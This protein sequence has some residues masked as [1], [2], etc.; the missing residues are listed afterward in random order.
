[1]SA[2]SKLFEELLAKDNPTAGDVHVASTGKDN[3]STKAQRKAKL[4]SVVNGGSRPV[5]KDWA[6]FDADRMAAGGKGG[7]GAAQH[8]QRLKDKYAAVGRE[9]GWDS[10]EAKAAEKE[11]LM[12]QRRY[13]VVKTD[14][15]RT[16][17][18]AKIDEDQRLVF[19]WAS[20]IEVNGEPVV[21]QQG[22]IIMAPEMEKSFYGFVTDSRMAGEM[23]DRMDAGHLVECIVFTKEK[24]EALGIEFTDRRVGTW[25]G[26]R[27]D[28]DAFAKVKS[29]DYRAFSI[30][31]R[32][33]RAAA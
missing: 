28:V 30:G 22:D 16:I 2:V 17:P 6:Q 33:V 26:F 11:M 23:H 21:D 32:G 7:R 20:V 29:G 15:S 14:W 19:G 1:M 5:A 8:L 12:A 13:G 3:A 10:P 27:V 9:E 4:F 25:V 18:I 24:K 31:G